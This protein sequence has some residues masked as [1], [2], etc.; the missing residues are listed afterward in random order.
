M[1]KIAL[2]VRF[3]II[4]S[5]LLVAFFLILSLFGLHTKPMFSLLNGVITGFGIYETIRY[6]KLEQGKNFTYTGGFTVGLVSGFIATLLFTVFFLFYATEIDP[7]FLEKLLNVFKGDYRVGVGLVAFVVAI[8]GFATTV[9]L[10]LT[11][12]QLFKNSNNVAQN[13]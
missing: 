6:Y 5:A 3:G 11:C 7:L 8:M 9:V 13:V 1:R 2:P 12:M 4:I 10:T